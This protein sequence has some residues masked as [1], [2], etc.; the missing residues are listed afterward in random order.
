MANP[1]IEHESP[2]HGV[3]SLTAHWNGTPVDDRDGALR[4]LQAICLTMLQARWRGLGDRPSVVEAA[5]ESLVELGEHLS[6]LVGSEGYRA[7]LA[8]GLQLASL[9]FPSLSDVHPA[10]NPPGRLI[11]LRKVVRRV[12]PAEGLEAI[13]ATLAGVLWLL[14]NFIGEDLTR[15]VLGEAWEWAPDTGLHALD[16]EP[17]RRL[18]A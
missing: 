9:E 15:R 13:A 11:G 4:A 1:T 12:P 17:V 7:L 16:G 5:E 8:R 10:L 18:T 14:L 2:G 6:R 3:S